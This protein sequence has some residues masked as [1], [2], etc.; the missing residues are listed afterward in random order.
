VVGMYPTSGTMA[1]VGDGQISLPE[2]LSMQI[3]TERL[4]MA[5]GSL[6]LQAKGVQPELHVPVTLDNVTS[7]NDVVLKYG[8][9]IVLQPLGAELTPPALPKLETSYAT[10]ETELQGGTILLDRMA[11]EKCQQ[12]DYA[13]RVILLTGS[14]S[15]HPKV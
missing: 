3:P 8:E 15:T 10:A 9:K 12:I 2:G 1:D 4:I 7:T 6:F 5:D 14:I 11:M 13:N